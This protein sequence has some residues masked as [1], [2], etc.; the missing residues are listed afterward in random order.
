M[1]SQVL[2]VMLKRLFPDFEGCLC[3]LKYVT[4]MCYSFYNK[5]VVRNYENKFF[6]ALFV[7]LK[8]VRFLKFIFSLVYA[9]FNILFLHLLFYGSAS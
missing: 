3:T 2:L 9:K 4:D 5:L 7:T 6:Y 8:T 1:K